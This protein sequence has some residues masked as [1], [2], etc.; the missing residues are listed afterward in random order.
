MKK[1]VPSARGLSPRPVVDLQQ[2][3]NFLSSI[4]SRFP[5][6]IFDPQGGRL[7]HY[8]DHIG[9]IGIIRDHDLWLTHSRYSNDE[10][11]MKHRMG[12]VQEVLAEELKAATT[13]ESKARLN[14]QATSRRIRGAGNRR[15][16]PRRPSGLPHPQLSVA[17]PVSPYPESNLAWGTVGAVPPVG[18]RSRDPVGRRGRSRGPAGSPAALA[19]AVCRQRVGGGVSGAAHGVLG[20]IC[21]AARDSRPVASPRWPALRASCRCR[22]GPALRAGWSAV[23]GSR[24]SS[25]RI[26]FDRAA[27]ALRW[28]DGA[29]QRTLNL[30]NV[31]VR[32]WPD[33][34]LAAC[35][36]RARLSRRGP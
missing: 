36:A 5:A 2:L 14:W 30:E 22:I 35:A 24:A 7:Y 9:L 13:A 19:P 20:R 33:P 32:L 12:V 28:M 23:S 21:L 1:Q 8:T 3:G 15:S 26:E 29:S 10:E 11:E 6:L 31:Y 16:S 25:A 34:P 17:S 4:D 27:F 18:E